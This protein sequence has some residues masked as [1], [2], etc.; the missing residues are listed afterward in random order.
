MT[1]SQARRPCRR[2][3]FTLA[4]RRASRPRAGALRR[5]QPRARQP[6]A[7]RWA[8]AVSGSRG[9]GQRATASRGALAAPRTAAAD[10]SPRRQRGTLERAQRA[11]QRRRPARLRPTAPR[12]CGSCAAALGR[13]R[14]SPA[15]WS[16]HARA[17]TA[18]KWPRS[19]S[20]VRTPEPHSERAMGAALT[21][22][23]GI[24][25]ALARYSC[26]RRLTISIAIGA[27]FGHGTRTRT[28][29][30]T[31][32]GR[33]ASKCAVRP[34]SAARADHLGRSPG[35]QITTTGSPPGCRFSF[36]LLSP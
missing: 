1:G 28:L 36:R 24:V 16:T 13:R 5:R 21:R 12:R 11:I 35:A 10:G 6:P 18:C 25:S 4:I 2:H 31:L 8:P 34:Q 26:V 15:R 17:T 23:T 20:V 3:S 30:R 19:R 33:E 7:Q 14:R 9:I 27:A 32:T 29:S 22:P